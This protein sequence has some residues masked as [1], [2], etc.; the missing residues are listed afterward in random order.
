MI[1][2]IKFCDT[3]ICSGENAAMTLVSVETEKGLT[4][5][6]KERLQKIVDE[7]KEENEEWYFDTVVEE[8][9]EKYFKPLG[10]KYETIEVSAVI[11]V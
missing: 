7:I 8:A 4:N 9:C 2:L 1:E 10:V 6:D 11:D 5:G 3:D